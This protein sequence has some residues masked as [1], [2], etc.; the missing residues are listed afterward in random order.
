[1]RHMHDVMA[2]HI[3]RGDVPGL[4][5]LVSRRGEAH[6][7]ALGVQTA[8]GRAMK[9]DSLFRIASMTKPVTAAATMI[10][11]EDGLVRL[12]EPVDRLLP[13]LADRRVLKSVE[14]PL[15]DTVPADRP[16]TIRDLLTFTLGYGYLFSEKPSPVDEAIARLGLAPGPPRPSDRPPPD[17]FMRR[18][19][20]LPLLFQPGERWL[21]NTGAEVLSVLVARASGRPFE[22]F[23]KERLFDPLGMKDTAFAVPASSVDRL[24]TAYQRN[25]RTGTVDVFDPSEGSDW[26]HPPAFPNGAAG[27]LSTVD[28][29][30]AF[31]AM[32]MD[33]GRHGS[34]RILSRP[35]VELMTTDRLTPEQKARSGLLPGFF[36]GHG[37][38]FCLY[39]VTERSGLQS[40]GSYGWTGGL[41]SAWDSDPREQMITI[42]LTN[43]LWES[44]VPPAVFED[45]ATLAYSAIDD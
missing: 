18:L 7:V 30:L 26:T 29:Y 20:S 15:D 21:Y 16:I 42:L 37:W 25:P 22:A 35:S 33:F 43:K 27:L 24:T 44:P 9:R 3:E 17:E 39:V 2:G 32:L 6:V 40:V 8:G 11:V 13:E 34:T 36:A 12:D 45:F 41:G 23:L 31:A 14:G 19:G 10:L 1:M 38:G 28:D 4:V 5:G